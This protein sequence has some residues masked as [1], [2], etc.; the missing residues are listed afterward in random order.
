MA[1]DVAALTGQALR[2][3]SSTVAVTAATTVT[4]TL[5]PGTVDQGPQRDRLIVFIGC[6]GLTT[7]TPPDGWDLIHTSRARNG[8]AVVWVYTRLADHE[9]VGWV[10]T[11]GTALP[12]WAWV[13]AYHS[14]R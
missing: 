3:S 12:G 8:R 14:V 6:A 7:C 4:A 13:G 5:P 10:F 1:V 2:S 11:L 9:D